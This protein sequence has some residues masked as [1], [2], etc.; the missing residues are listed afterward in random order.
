MEGD[1]SE[2]KNSTPDSGSTP[3]VSPMTERAQNF[4][5]RTYHPGSFEPSEHFYPRCLNAQMHATVHHFLS[6][7]NAQIASRFCHTRPEFDRAELLTYL[8]DYKPQ[9]MLWSG[10]DLM[11]VTE[12]ESG[13]SG[14]TII[15][16]NSC[17]SGQKS[18]PLY[19]ETVEDGGYGKL[20]RNC[21]IPEMERRKEMGMLP[22]GE[23]GVIYDKNLMEV[24]GYAAALAD[25]TGEP[26]HLIPAWSNTELFGPSIYKFENDILYTRRPTNDPVVTS[27][28]WVPIRAA[29]RYVTQKPWSKIPVHLPLGGTFIVNPIIACLAGG[30][31]KLVAAK[32]YDNM[33][34]ELDAASLPRIRTP[35]TIRDVQFND[36]RKWVKK[37]GG[38]ACIKVPYSNGGQ[39][40]YTITSEQELV[41]F[42]VKESGNPYNLFIIQSLIANSN[43]SSKGFQ[44][45]NRA[46]LYHNGTVPNK[47]N[48]IYV[49]D[50][51]IQVCANASGGGFR[52]VA[53]YARR[54]AKPLAHTLPS[55][56]GATSWEMLGTN[57]SVVRGHGLFSSESGR[58]LL[59]DR[60]DFNTLGLSLDNLIDAFVQA[61]F[62]HVAVDRMA[63]F[64]TPKGEF[65]EDFFRAMCDDDHLIEEIRAGIALNR[66]TA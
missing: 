31:N 51:R 41:E 14:C 50:L 43:W 57:L 1:K 37:L 52:P 42:E 47:K 11:Y 58:L 27:E 30:R 48:H 19:D 5:S 4:P 6:L 17:A 29:F 25:I 65:S 24:S 35:L 21:F 2:T 36:I 33:S 23:L 34:I 49:C 61:C 15:E 56:D 44:G 32:A 9:H 38:H 46:T 60:K 66:K 40:V 22:E 64:L 7:S 28:E 39:G 10:S 3:V 62:A 63:D 53:M 8:N 26:V 20:L 45:G 54:A 13:R 12:R 16:T 18:N 55:P 59:M